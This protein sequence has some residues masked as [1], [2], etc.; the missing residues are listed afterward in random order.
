[1]TTGPEREMS[2]SWEF[3]QCPHAFYPGLCRECV[4][5]L[6]KSAEQAAYERGIE[7]AAKIAEDTWDYIPQETW[8]EGFE[9]DYKLTQDTAAERIRSLSRKEQI[10]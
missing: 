9:P 3:S 8:D 6:V 2:A 4:R 5:A 1:M 7:D 10:R